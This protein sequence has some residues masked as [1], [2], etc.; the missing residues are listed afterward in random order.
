[1]KD[2]ANNREPRQYAQRMM[3]LCKDAGMSTEQQQVD[4]IYNGLD[5]ELRWAIRHPKNTSIEDFTTMLDE[6]KYSWWDTA[7]QRRNTANRG[8]HNARTGNDR[9]QNSYANRPNNQ[10]YLNA[11][12]RP[13]FPN[14]QNY[15][16]PNPYQQ[17]P[18]AGYQ[19]RPSGTPNGL[20]VPQ[21]QP[22]QVPKQI[23]AQFT[24]TNQQRPSY[25]GNNYGNRGNYGNYNN[26]G[27]NGNYSNR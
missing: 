22:P 10:N 21:L 12:P 15:G 7:K 16:R 5:L 23:T 24:N 18:N 26:R 1:M 13:W 14:S 11:Y 9:H 4:F 25:Q 27:N 8:N 19:G 20:Y 2:A 6:L 3:Q 17:Q